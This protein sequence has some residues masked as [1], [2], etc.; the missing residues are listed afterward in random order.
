MVTDTS[1]LDQNKCP[2]LM[3]IER[4]LALPGDGTF[5][6][7]TSIKALGH[8]KLWVFEDSEE[9]QLRANLPGRVNHG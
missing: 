6:W 8:P 9:A 4:N 5:H 2:R 1:A 7:T 3:A